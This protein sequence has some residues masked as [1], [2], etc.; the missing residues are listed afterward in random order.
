V[1]LTRAQ[2][3]A[4]IATGTL[5]L[6]AV[7]ALGFVVPARHPSRDQVDNALVLLGLMGLLLALLLPRSGLLGGGSVIRA[8]L[9]I[10]GAVGTLAVGLSDFGPRQKVGWAIKL[11]AGAL[12]LL[13]LRGLG[14]RAGDDLR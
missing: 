8:S 4:G 12:F 6:T 3:L 10:L 1:P 2:S 9:A 13:I 11:A 5:A 14:N 7:V